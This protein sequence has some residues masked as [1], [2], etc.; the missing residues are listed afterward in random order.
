MIVLGADTHKRSHTLAAIDVATGQ[1]LGDTTVQVGPRGLATIVGLGA[2]ARWPAGV[3]LGGLPARFGRAGSASGRQ[4][5]SRW[6]SSTCRSRKGAD[7]ASAF[8]SLACS[9]ADRRWGRG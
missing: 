4:S 8:S 9:Q 3:G 5:L 1:V 6:R 2:P 7:G